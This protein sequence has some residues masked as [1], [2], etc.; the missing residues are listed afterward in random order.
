MFQ[1]C[2]A[3]S[4][5]LLLLDVNWQSKRERVEQKKEKNAGVSRRIIQSIVVKYVCEYQQ[6]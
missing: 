4:A 3:L 2:A 5:R 1:S 6:I